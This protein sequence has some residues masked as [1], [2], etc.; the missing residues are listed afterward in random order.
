MVALSL[1]IFFKSHE[2]LEMHAEVFAN[3]M[4]WVSLCSNPVG[5]EQQIRQ[6]WRM[7]TVVWGLCCGYVGLHCTVLSLLSFLL[8]S[9]YG[10]V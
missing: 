2:L 4:I 10:K 8:E 9:F 7:L 1:F 3:E 6:D 5:L